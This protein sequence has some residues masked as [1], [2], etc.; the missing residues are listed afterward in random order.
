MKQFS[1]IILFSIYLVNIGYSQDSTIE[2][3][4][5][6]LRR[7][8][9]KNIVLDDSL[10]SGKKS[11]IVLANI[12]LDKKGKFLSSILLYSDSSRITQSVSKA[13]SLVSSDIWKKFKNIQN[14]FIPIFFV[15]DDG[16]SEFCLDWLDINLRKMETNYMLGLTMK[17]IVTILSEPKRIK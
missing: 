7:S 17:P 4:V 15:Y 8:I 3:G 5:I 14:I 6:D 1:L 11:A 12:K 9:Q 10:I 2:R 13:F 16:E